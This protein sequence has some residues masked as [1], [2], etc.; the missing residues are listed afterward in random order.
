MK[1]IT[2]VYFS[3]AQI[4]IHP[5]IQPFL[6]FA[7]TAPNFCITALQP[8]SLHLSFPFNSC[9][10]C[11]HFLLFSSHKLHRPILLPNST[12]DLLLLLQTPP[13]SIPC[14]HLAFVLYVFIA[15]L[16]IAVSRNY[17]KKEEK[18]SPTPVSFFTPAVM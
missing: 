3:F 11:S 14:F 7:Y 12:L 4:P 2:Q 9:S 10:H 16:Q 6:P 13:V 15:L 8:V 17:L 1:G 5:A 18:A